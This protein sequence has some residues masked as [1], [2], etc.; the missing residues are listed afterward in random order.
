MVSR[1]LAGF[2]SGER[3]GDEAEPWL[4][5]RRGRADA[6]SLVCAVEEWY[7]TPGRGDKVK[8]RAWATKR[9]QCLGASRASCNQPCILPGSAAPGS[10]VL[11]LQLAGV[12]RAG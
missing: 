5:G 8:K 7:E 11:G 12:L 10:P 6:K 3:E 9:F 4:M 2:L 1:P